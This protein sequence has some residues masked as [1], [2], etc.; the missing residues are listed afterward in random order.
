MR[1]TI[2]IDDQLLAEAKAI[3]ARSGRTLNAVVEDALRA[4]IAQRR[5][6]RVPSTLVLPTFSGSRLRRGINLDD[7]AGLLDV[8]RAG[9][10]M[11]VR[12]QYRGRGPSTDRARRQARADDAAAGR[13]Q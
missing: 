8:M 2:T 12:G 7:G 13:N 11:T 10:V 5:G 4:M 6:V 9:H 1:T 3:A